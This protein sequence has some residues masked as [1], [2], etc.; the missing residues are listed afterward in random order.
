MRLSRLARFTTPLIVLMFA[1][2]A[3][4]PTAVYA[5]PLS[6]EPTGG[7]GIVMG[8][9]GLVLLLVGVVA[10]IGAVALGIIG[11]GYNTVTPDDE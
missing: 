8:L 10:V 4:A 11:I 9:L 6:E 1:V 3:L 7:A 2:L 5:A